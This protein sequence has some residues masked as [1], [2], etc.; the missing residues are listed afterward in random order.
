ILCCSVL[1]LFPVI[2]DK[3]GDILTKGL[4]NHR[5]HTT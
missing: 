4:K 1:Y 3:E 5:H 2:R